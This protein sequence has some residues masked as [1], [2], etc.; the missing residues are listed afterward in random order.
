MLS[1]LILARPPSG[2]PSGSD[3]SQTGV[4]DS[5]MP[6]FSQTSPDRAIGKRPAHRA[7]STP[8]A[9]R[10]FRNGR[11][12]G[13]IVEFLIEKSMTGPSCLVRPCPAITM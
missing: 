12:G 7:A 1:D 11:Y 4:P 10:T 2:I 3:S 13:L 8:A 6:F 5:F 9:T